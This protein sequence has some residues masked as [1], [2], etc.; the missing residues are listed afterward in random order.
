MIWLKVGISHL[1]F[2][3]NGNGHSAPTMAFTLINCCHA[4]YWSHPILSNNSCFD[5]PSL[6]IDPLANQTILFDRNHD[7]GFY[8]T[9]PH[10]GEFP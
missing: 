5:F 6:F 1:L 4:M 9:Q 3:Q 7:P 8:V 2:F 10:F